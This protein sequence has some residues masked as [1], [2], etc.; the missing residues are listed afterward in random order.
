MR[1]V[2]RQVFMF[3]VVPVTAAGLMIGS[4]FLAPDWGIWVVFAVPLALIAAIILRFG[5]TLPDDY[6]PRWT[7][8]HGVTI[9]DGNRQ[10]IRRYLLHGRRIRTVGA[11][12]GYLG[13]TVYQM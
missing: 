4:A 12:S 2:T 6:M 3:L 1:R 9:T 11:L 8:A 13:Y 7:K 10:M 5:F